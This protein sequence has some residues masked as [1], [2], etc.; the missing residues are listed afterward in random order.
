ML[1][2]F[3]FKQNLGKFFK[4]GELAFAHSGKEIFSP[5]GPAVLRVNLEENWTRQLD[6]RA[7]S[8]VLKMEICFDDAMLL[9]A[10][11]LGYLFLYNVSKSFI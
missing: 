1:S 4:S 5:T 6:F 11:A 3:D 2:C 9:M 10:D 7:N 8:D